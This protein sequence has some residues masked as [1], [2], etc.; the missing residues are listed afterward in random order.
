[1]IINPL[2]AIDFYKADHRRQY[3]D[4]TT[5]VYANFTPRSH[6]HP[7]QL[8]A[9]DTGV[10]FFGL[11]YFIKEFL[12]ETWDAN[13]FNQPKA[14]V[15][16]A[17]KRRMDFALGVN[18]IDTQHIAALHDLGYLPIKIKALTEG[19]YVPIG[20]PVLTIKNT[21]TLIFSG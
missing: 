11:Q 16:A 6:R 3:P 1:M 2:T 18:A 15:V 8:N 19:A 13:F 21:P 12:I 17:Y 4:G 5:E 9:V 14:K 20:V 7:H 10:I